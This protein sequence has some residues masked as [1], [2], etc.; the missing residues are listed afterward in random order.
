[1]EAI[2]RETNIG[3]RLVHVRCDN[4]RILEESTKVRLQ[5]IFNVWPGHDTWKVVIWIMGSFGLDEMMVKKWWV[6]ECDGD[7]EVIVPELKTINMGSS[8]EWV[9]TIDLTIWTSI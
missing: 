7:F 3:G 4:L 1:M 2:T 8:E 6:R 9:Y 5:W